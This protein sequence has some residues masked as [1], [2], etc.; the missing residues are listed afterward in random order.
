MST[1]SPTGEPKSQSPSPS[2]ALKSAWTFGPWHGWHRINRKPVMLRPQ[3]F[4][5]SCR[6]F[7]WVWQ[8][9]KPPMFDGLYHPLMIRGMVYY[10]YT[11]IS[12]FSFNHIWAVLISDFRPLRMWKV[13]CWP[14][15]QSHSGLPS[16]GVY[17]VPGRFL[18]IKI[19]LPSK[20][21]INHINIW[22]FNIA[23][24]NPL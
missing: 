17:T 10:C 2:R 22:L 20:C 1:I 16:S 11:N 15:Y 18:S 13:P 8:C 4:Q 14:L 6:C 12:R 19:D 5:V 7:M 23:M 24:E 21:F 9:H 3:G